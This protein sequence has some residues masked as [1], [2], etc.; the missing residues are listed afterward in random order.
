MADNTVPITAGTGTSIRTVT[1]AGAD[2]GAHQQVIS[3][4]DSV[5]NLVPADPDGTLNTDD[6]PSNLLFEAFDGTLANQWVVS[7]SGSPAQASGALTFS[8]STATTSYTSLLTGINALPM[9]PS[10][11]LQTAFVVQI[12]TSASITN[13]T[14]WWG[15]GTNQGSPTAAAPVLN[16]AVFM[17]DY[18]AGAFMAAVYSA[19]TRTQSVTLTKPT[20][21]AYHRYAIWYRTSRAYFIQDGVTVATIQFPNTSVSNNQFIIGGSVNFTTVPSTAPTMVWSST[22]AGDGGGNTT[23]LSDATYPSV[24]ATVKKSSTAAATTDTALVVALHPSTTGNVSV[25]SEV[26]GTGAT[27]LGKAQAATPGTT[28]TGVGMLAVRAP[29]TPVARTATAGNYSLA[30]VDAEGKQII[31]QYADPTNTWQAVATQT[32]TTAAAVKAAGAAGIRNYVTGITVSNSSATATLVTILD[33]ATVIWQTWLGAGI[34]LTMPFETPLRGTAATAVNVNL[35]VAVTSV[36]VA[37]Q[38]YLGI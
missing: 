34:S 22:S 6:G 17:L 24:R 31:Q 23:W 2:N 9:T 36:Y 16:G 29:T 5:G 32:S 33:G 14:R 8:T 20:D 15:Y 26:P 35:S 27:N 10:S 18:S 21:G 25:T 4:A 13:N 19:G 3:L 30:V 12:D 37:A 1:N 28:D 11:Y 38:G 7:G